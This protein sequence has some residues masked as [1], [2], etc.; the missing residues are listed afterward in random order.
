MSATIVA[1]T[2]R[3]D[4]YFERFG[5]C[6]RQI[7]EPPAPGLS[8]VVV[9]PCFNEPNLVGSLESLRESERPDTAHEVI[10]VVNSAADAEASIIEQNERTLRDARAWIDAQPEPKLTVRLIDARD[11]PPRHAGVGLAR[12]IGMDEAL[13]RFDAVDTI[14]SGLIL[15]FDADCACASDYLRAVDEHFRA[16][17]MSSACSIYFE[18]PLEGELAA[19]IYEAIAAYELHLRYYVQALRY[20][21]LPHAYHTIG[22]SMAVRARA[23]M[24][25]GGM[26][27][28]Q[29]GEDFYFLHKLIPLGSFTELNSTAVYPSPRPSNR[30]PFG[31]GRAVSEWLQQPGTKTYP[32]KAFDDL[33]VFLQSVASLKTADVQDMPESIRT[34]LVRQDFD[35][36]I[37]EIGRHTATPAAFSKRF[38]R[39]FDGFRAMK[40]V[41]HARDNFYG[42]EAVEVASAKLLGR[43][44]RPAVGDSIEELLLAYRKLNRGL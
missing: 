3:T 22:S 37:A 14:D 6:E 7:P 28:R 34:F 30:V 20:G 24:E 18:H 8:L 44:D 35:A 26:N 12:K 32:F 10:V 38:F 5:F 9:I 41:H 29:A 40:F 11:L 15:C 33:R 39:W 42:E 31:T 2:R 36:A 13:R 21:G 19:E 25:Q 16:H 17:P 43:L 23:Y 27:R 1:M 4:A